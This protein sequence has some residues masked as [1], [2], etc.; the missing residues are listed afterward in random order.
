MNQETICYCCGG[1]KHIR[2]ECY[3]RNKYCS[4]CGAKGHIYK[5]CRKTGVKQQP[6][7]SQNYVDGEVVGEQGSSSP[8][9]DNDRFETD[10]FMLRTAE[11]FSKDLAAN[12]PVEVMV[13]PQFEIITV[14]DIPLKMEV[15][16]G[17]GPAV[18]LKQCYENFFSHILL[19]KSRVIL[20][21]YNKLPIPCLGYITVFAEKN[22]IKCNLLL[23]IVQEGGP[24]LLGRNWLQVFGMWPIPFQN[25]VHKVD[26]NKII[27]QGQN[28]KEEKETQTDKF[29][30]DFPNVFKAGIGTFTK[31]ELTLKADAR[32]KFMQPRK[33]Y[34][35]RYAKKS[36]TN[37]QNYKHLK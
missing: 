28:I 9:T 23:H 16:S 3:L 24:P 1:K 15:D 30:R 6:W 14:N 11:I 37:C 2:S 35:G 29:K 34:P 22:G 27:S 25:K 8:V 19:I 20:R 13:D 31:G 17:P 21:T 4:E 10:F 7:R 18:I 5:M 12:P 33:I 32:P 36:N 26:T